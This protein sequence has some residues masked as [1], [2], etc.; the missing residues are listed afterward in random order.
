MPLRKTAALEQQQFL[1]PFEEV[2]ALPRI[3]AG[4]QRVGGDR[5]GA[6]CAAEA[7]IDAAGN[8]ASST[9]KRSATISGAW[10]GNITPPEP[11]R[12]CDVIAAIC[13]IMISGAELAMFAR[14]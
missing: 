11:T 2:V 3:L 4:A 10:F 13:P 1:E 6:G 8:N 5:I 9:L 12:M 7:K 14:L